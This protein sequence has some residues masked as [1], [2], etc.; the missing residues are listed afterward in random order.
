MFGLLYLNVPLL[1]VYTIYT[2][3]FFFYVCYCLN[4]LWRFTGLCCLLLLE[5][6]AKTEHVRRYIW[7]VKKEMDEM[8]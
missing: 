5:E 1:W 8:R 6:K 2:Y 3:G 4:P 7:V